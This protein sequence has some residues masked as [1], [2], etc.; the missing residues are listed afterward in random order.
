[1]RGLVNKGVLRA[2]LG[3]AL[4]ALPAAGG[5]AHDKDKQSPAVA[6]AEAADRVLAAVE[7]GVAARDAGALAALWGAADRPQ[8]EG[9]I[10]QGLAGPRVAELAVSLVSVRVVDGVM[11]VQAAWNGTLNGAAA[12]GRFGLRLLPEADY[13]IAAATGE[14]PWAVA[15]RSGPLA[16][17]ATV[18]LE[19]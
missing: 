6:Y 13:A 15:L 9:R 3:L 17:S 11:T 5:C 4:L 18:G 1:M 10:G 12:S 7:A 8:A 2:L 19:P 14:L 16:P